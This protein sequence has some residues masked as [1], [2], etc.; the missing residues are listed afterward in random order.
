[1]RVAADAASES[2]S[3]RPGQGC[4]P[5]RKRSKL[6]RLIRHL[7]RG[8]RG[9]TLPP[10]VGA[11]SSGLLLLLFSEL[12]RRGRK[13]APAGS[14]LTVIVPALMNYSGGGLKFYFTAAVK[15]TQKNEIKKP[16]IQNPMNSTFFTLRAAGTVM[17]CAFSMILCAALSNAANSSLNRRPE[18]VHLTHTK[19]SA[20]KNNINI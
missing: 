8:S 10:R 2:E 16:F 11:N 20:V 6:C 12:P 19:N 15:N 3:E 9:A 17:N 18:Y 4:G 7:W 1:M 13:L 5:R 14:P